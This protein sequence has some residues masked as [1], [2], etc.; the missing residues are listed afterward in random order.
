MLV[1]AP[2]VVR[3]MC[4]PGVPICREDEP[5][6]LGM[7]GQP[8]RAEGLSQR[9]P[10]R[11]SPDKPGGP[12]FQRRSYSRAK[13]RYLHP[14]PSS[15]GGP[16]GRHRPDQDGKLRASIEA[17]CSHVDVLPACSQIRAALVA[18][19]ALSLQS[20]A[21]RPSPGELGQQYWLWSQDLETTT[22]LRSIRWLLESR[23]HR[24]IGRA[25]AHRRDSQRRSGRTPAGKGHQAWRFLC[26]MKHPHPE[27]GPNEDLQ[28]VERAMCRRTSSVP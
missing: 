23:R 18:P 12:R 1:W 11:N 7:D 13:A 26:G 3:W 4:G 19:A 10:S 27:R 15:P 5:E 21:S 16:G 20:G 28:R 6:I 25:P 2:A 22:F 24:G 9:A 8:T 17:N 14:V